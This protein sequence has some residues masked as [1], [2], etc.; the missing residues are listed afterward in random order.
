MEAVRGEENVN[1]YAGIRSIVDSA[2]LEHTKQVIGDEKRRADLC[3]ADVQTALNKHDC[4]IVPKCIISPNGVEFQV[5]TI[6]RM[7][8]HEQAKGQ[9]DAANT[10]GKKD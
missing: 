1:V 2:I 7:H 9:L 10:Q 5:E 6:P 8:K 3:M 4:V